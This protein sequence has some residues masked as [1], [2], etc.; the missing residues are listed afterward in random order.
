MYI[1]LNI[2]YMLGKQLARHGKFKVCF[3]ELSEFF[4]PNIFNPR[5]V[6]LQMQTPWRLCMLTH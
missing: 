3:L 5:L 6:E 1:V 2:M 4:P